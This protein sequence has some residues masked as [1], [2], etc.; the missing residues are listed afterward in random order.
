MVP[1]SLPNAQGIFVIYLR[2]K[3]FLTQQLY[4]IHTLSFL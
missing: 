3:R 2:I 1:L 4:D